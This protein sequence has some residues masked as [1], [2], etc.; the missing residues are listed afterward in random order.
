W[1]AGFA[2][3]VV[4]VNSQY[5]DASFC[6]RVL[7]QAF[8]A[9]LPPNVDPCGENGEFHTFV[10]QAPYFKAPINVQTGETVSKKY[11]YKTAT[12][13]ESTSTYYFV[14]LCLV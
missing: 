6:G 2:T 5:L 13:E 1:A 7:D 14:D 8:V 10:Y 3:V 11:I 9:D 12:G 4:S